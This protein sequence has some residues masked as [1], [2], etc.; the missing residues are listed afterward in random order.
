MQSEQQ[1]V[2]GSSANEQSVV[3]QSSTTITADTVVSLQN[4]SA[5]KSNDENSPPKIVDYFI[6]RPKTCNLL[7]V[8][9]QISILKMFKWFA[10][11]KLFF[12]EIHLSLLEL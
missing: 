12:Y 10:F 7:D 6:K 11:L 1:T 5:G 4:R 9:H 3:Y 2:I 8:S